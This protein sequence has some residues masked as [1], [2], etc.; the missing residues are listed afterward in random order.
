MIINAWWHSYVRLFKQWQSA[1]SIIY[2]T[3]CGVFVWC[4]VQFSLMSPYIA[5]TYVDFRCWVIRLGSTKNRTTIC[6]PHHLGPW[7]F[8]YVSFWR[9]ALCPCYYFQIFWRLH[10]QLFSSCAPE[11]Y[12]TWWPFQPWNMWQVMC[13]IRNV[14]AT[15]EWSMSF[16]Y[17]ATSLYATDGLSGSSQCRLLCH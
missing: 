13:A 14:C 5:Q 17:W 7:C 3:L 16:C 12:Y 9:M 6:W 10:G 4:S 15:N 1:T 2:L 11:L 8:E